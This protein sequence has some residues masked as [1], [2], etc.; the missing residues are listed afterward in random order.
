MGKD[1]N[2]GE[3]HY[4]NEPLKFAADAL[5]VLLAWSA[6][7]ADAEGTESF[8]FGLSASRAFAPKFERASGELSSHELDHVARSQSELAV[9]GFEGSSVF[10]GH[11]DDSVD[12]RIRQRSVIELVVMVFVV[13][14]VCA[15]QECE[16][17]HFADPARRLDT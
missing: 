15:N 5:S 14:H 17:L 4:G 8:V 9:N 12:V 6:E 13:W 11:L 10:P 3:F 1:R 7:A 16:G 2:S